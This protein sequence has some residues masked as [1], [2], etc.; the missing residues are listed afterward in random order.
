MRLF[1]FWCNSCFLPSWSATDNIGREATNCA[2]CRSTARD[3]AVLLAVHST[4]L[5]K[6][7]RNPFFLNSIRII[8]VSDG[9]VI[10]RSLKKVYRKKYSNFHFH[11]DPRLD[12]T[13]VSDRLIGAA[14]I[15]VCS[16]VLEHVRPPVK[17]AFD[18]LS[19]LLRQ[20]GGSIVLSVPHSDS[21]SFHLE[22]FVELREERIVR[23][24]G[25]NFLIGIND[26]GQE[27]EYGNLVFHG[28]EG[29]TLEYRV[30]SQASLFDHLE[31]AGF[32]EYVP[33]KNRRAFGIYWEPWSRVWICKKTK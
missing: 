27:V 13:Q 23:R 8:G 5:N 31:N 29:H 21:K 24:A 16:E 20:S 18:G 9:S 12:I 2:W 17:R 28:G 32:R 33:V 10:E 30:F 3:R 11:Q 19:K 7:I 15:V 1:F 6:C 22:H 4:V 14:D 26:K 25:S